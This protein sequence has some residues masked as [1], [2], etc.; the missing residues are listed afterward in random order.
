[1]PTIRI[2]LA[3]ASPLVCGAVDEAVSQDS[4]LAVTGEAH[5]PVELLLRAAGVDVVVLEVDGD[6]LPGSAEL[7]IDENPRIG[8]VGVDGDV[9]GGLVYRLRPQTQSIGPVTARALIDAIREAASADL[10]PTRPLREA[11]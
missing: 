7:L 2:L 3:D 11:T 1:L 5:G 6:D 9:S 4:E 8:I 10:A